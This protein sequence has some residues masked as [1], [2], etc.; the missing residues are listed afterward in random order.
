MLVH[1]ISKE[2][3]VCLP[4]KPSLSDENLI[5]YQDVFENLDEQGVKI[6]IYI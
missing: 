4:C 3:I 1:E 6:T 2:H 5:Q